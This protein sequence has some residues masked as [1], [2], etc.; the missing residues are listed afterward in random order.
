MED[1]VGSITETVERGHNVLIT[2]QA[3]T[4]KTTLLAAL[5]DRLKGQGKAVAYTASSGIASRSLNGETVHRWA[6][7]QV[8]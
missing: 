3:G 4:G 6:G 7:I 1:I 5:G 2:G 8:N